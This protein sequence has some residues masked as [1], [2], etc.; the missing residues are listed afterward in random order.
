MDNNESLQ[1]GWR[2]MLWAN[3]FLIVVLITIVWYRVLA[4]NTS[5][6]LVKENDAE[7]KVLVEIS[8]DAATNDSWETTMQT[9]EDK[10]DV[11]VFTGTTCTAKIINNNRHDIKDWN[12]K[13]NIQNDCYLNG[14]WC[15][16]FEVHQFRNNEEKVNLIN[17]QD[18][19]LSKLDI[20]YNIYSE[21][22]MI[23]LLPGDYLKYEPSV[24]E[25]EDVVQGNDSVGIGFIFYYQGTLDLSEYELTYNNDLKIWND[26]FFIAIWIL[27]I[28][29]IG[30]FVNFLYIKTATKKI[31]S[32][33]NSRIK[34]MN[35]MSEIYLE[36]FMINLDNDSAMLI[37]GDESNLTFDIVGKNVQDRIYASVM[38]NCNNIYR[39]SLSS[40][41]NLST[42]KDRAKNTNNISYEY[43]DNELGWCVV[44]LFLVGEDKK[45]I[46]LAL[47]NINEEKT[48]VYEAEDRIQ[49]AEY[50]EFVNGNFIGSVSYAVDDIVSRTVSDCL[51]V[52]EELQSD[53]HHT[54][55][56]ERI[57]RVM[58]NTKHLTLVQNMLFDM[59]A[60]EAERFSL[61]E[62]AY[63]IHEMIEEV[64]SL[65]SPH[66][67]TDKYEFKV[68]VDKDIPSSLIGD[69]IRLEQI[70]SSILMSSLMVT[71]EGFVK[72]SVYGRNTGD[73]EELI[74]SVRDS[75][76]GFTE[77][78]IAEIHAFIGGSRIESTN[79]AS[80]VYIKIIH[81][82]LGYMNSA[83]RIVSVAGEGSEF[84]F[85][86][87]Q[88]ID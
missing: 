39:A 65:V 73:E 81:E 42:L 76:I 58:K 10:S 69:K 67:Q 79:N 41:L 17:M 24:H 83:L 1:K 77:E 87:K 33:L 85:S 28:I 34:S 35:I 3:G 63:D 15:G 47:Q 18:L 5:D 9:S 31:V 60:I 2:T 54:E 88:K 14:F 48:K 7:S 66:V 61:N 62:E 4:Y 8:G 52:Q 13:I 26:V 40:F 36:V 19:D 27:A 59:Y 12:L 78:Q 53:G 46:V 82:I 68:E 20:D 75:A 86:L 70:L 56:I 80:L 38:N 57:D 37:K 16:S 72:L 21:S 44:R 25:K 84:Y 51:I 23:H 32:E 49:M 6:V 22:V 43:V 50:K 55:Q 71:Q 64:I 29:W 45:Q 11:C 74:F 30:A